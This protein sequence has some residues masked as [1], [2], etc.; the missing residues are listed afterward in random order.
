MKY[1]GILLAGNGSLS[2]RANDSIT[3]L[4]QKKLQNHWSFVHFSKTLR[5]SLT[6]Q[7]K[8]NNKLSGPFAERKQTSLPKLYYF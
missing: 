6:R 8:E 4:L 7:T 5:G 2:T 1:N 3:S